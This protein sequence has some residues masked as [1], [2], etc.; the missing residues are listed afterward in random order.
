MTLFDMKIYTKSDA[1]LQKIK[2]SGDKSP[3]YYIR[4]AMCYYQL[5]DYNNALNCFKKINVHTLFSFSI[6]LELLYLK[7]RYFDIIDIQKHS[8]NNPQY[9]NFFENAKPF[10]IFLKAYFKVNVE[11]FSTSKSDILKQL[12]I[13]NFIQIKCIF[14]NI[15]TSFSYL[16]SL[17]NLYGCQQFLSISLLKNKSIYSEENVDRILNCIAK[18]T[19]EPIVAIVQYLYPNHHTIDQSFYDK[20]LYFLEKYNNIVTNNNINIVNFVENVEHS[21]IFSFDQL[22]NDQNFIRNIKKFYT[23]SD[24]IKLDNSNNDLAIITNN[25]SLT[26][27]DYWK[28]STIKYIF[29]TDLNIN[30]YLFTQNQFNIMDAQTY[31]DYS[32]IPFSNVTPINN[33]VKEL[34]TLLN[35]HKIGKILLFDV[36]DNNF[37]YFVHTN[38][39]NTYTFNENSQISQLFSKQCKLIDLFKSDM[40][41]SVLPYRYNFNE[42]TIEEIDISMSNNYVFIADELLSID[43]ITL[44]RLK[45]ILARDNSFILIFNSLAKNSFIIDKMKDIFTV[46]YHRIKIVSSDNYI[47]SKFI[48]YSSSIIA[49]NTNNVNSQLYLEAIYFNKV[50]LTIGDISN[51][52]YTNLVQKS[53]KPEFFTC[54]DI[55]ELIQKTI[56]M[57]HIDIKL[58]NFQLDEIKNT[59]GHESNLIPIFNA[60]NIEI[61]N[62]EDDKPDDESE[63][64]AENEQEKRVNTD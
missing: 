44:Y 3:E 31:V 42:K 13:S 10:E 55:N 19:I 47:S 1:N 24:K 52:F 28:F 35:K 12:K 26:K 34:N 29:M 7:H 62:K 25:S 6:Y 59:L 21:P 45:D 56:S 46:Y 4:L 63:E 11:S 41:N 22:I 58:H 9:K 30:V 18:N 54:E 16:P 8:K 23:L 2:Q 61:N 15:A 14:K 64:Q 20:R 37:Q 27:Y 17:D 57:S 5:C 43:T 38:Y 53:F 48:Y 40:I 50:I 36:L 49:I 39:T 32:G 33:N 60:L 51:I